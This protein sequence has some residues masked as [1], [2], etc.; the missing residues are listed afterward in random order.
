[1]SKGLLK[2]GSYFLLNN[3]ITFQWHNWTEAHTG[4]SSVLNSEPMKVD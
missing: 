2:K 1:M 3:E 4:W